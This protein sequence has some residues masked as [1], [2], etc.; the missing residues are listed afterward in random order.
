[1]NTIYP[2]Q[3]NVSSV[4]I[5]E[6][7]S[8]RQSTFNR[9]TLVVAHDLVGKMLVRWIGRQ[10]HS[11]IITETEA[12]IGE[13]DLACH[14]RFGRTK[15]NAALYGNA[16]SWYVYLVY[17]MHWMLN[18]VTE[19]VDKPAAVLIRSG[20]SIV[21]GELLRGPGIL[22]KALEIDG[23]VYGQSATV[24]DLQIHD[25]GKFPGR[26]LRTPRVGIDY[27]GKYKDKRWR[28]LLA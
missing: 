22:T 12:Y 9:P 5:S 6:G 28:F 3:I 24:G 16:G 27:A 7:R 14:A 17:G 4:K 11:V 1:M 10:R 19:K 20:V 15:R 2:R 26:I 18:V 25:I 8:L 21:S 13:E 23:R